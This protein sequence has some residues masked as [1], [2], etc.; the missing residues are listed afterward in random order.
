MLLPTLCAF[1][2]LTPQKEHSGHLEDLDL[3]VLQKLVG[4]EATK[5]VVAPGEVRQATGKD[6]DAWI[7]AGKAEHDSFLEA[8]AVVEATADD[9]KNHRSRPLPMLNV[10]SKVSDGGRKCRSCIAGNFQKFDPA[11]QRWT[12][13]AEPSSIFISAKMAALRGWEV[14]KLDVKGAF[15]NAPLPDGELILVEPP[16]QWKYWGIVGRNV[17]W[18]LKKAV[19]GLRQSPK[20]WSDERDAKLRTLKAKV[21]GSTYHLKQNEADTQVWTIREVG[22]EQ[23]LGALCVYVDDFLILAPREKF[24]P[25]SLKL[26]SRSGGLDQSVPCRH[27]RH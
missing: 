4:P 13:Q 1:A 27:R 10:W 12:A 21:K 8:H 22:K 17:V 26:F 23:I 20:W 2:A 14:S 16:K 25:G 6:L 9:I 24:A 3:E 15:L 11:A 5:S 18:R 7:L 19:Y